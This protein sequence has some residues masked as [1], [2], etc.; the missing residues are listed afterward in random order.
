V[1]RAFIVDHNNGDGV[2]AAML[3]CK[4]CA[5]AK[6]YAF[7][8]LDPE[9][10]SFLEANS[11]G[12]E[13]PRGTVVFREGDR[14][15]AVYVLCTGK[16][17]LS[18]TSRDGRTMILRI[19]DAGDALGMSAALMNS[20]HEVTA[21]TLEPS[22]VRVLHLRHLQE[23]LRSHEETGLNVARALAGDYRA[24]FDEASLIALPGSPAGRVARLI[25]NWAEKAKSNSSPFVI[26]SLTHEELAAMTATTRE[27]VTRTLSRMRKDG[28]IAT[29]GV[30]LTVLQP[31]V[32]ENLCAC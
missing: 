20:D 1:R 23:L 21:E 22:R 24:A 31:K 11:V 9:A 25:L 14:A 2:R 30:A 10:K 8:N 16:I 17:K 13:Y 28:V 6:K 5:N 19:A 26:M 7:C 29:R 4:D 12:M 27:T 32:L 15:C 3:N 18:V